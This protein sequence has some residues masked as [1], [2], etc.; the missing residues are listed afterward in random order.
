MRHWTYGLLAAIGRAPAHPAT[1]HPCPAP[2]TNKRSRGS[3]TRGARHQSAAA[4]QDRS[5]PISRD[6]GC[7]RGRVCTVCGRLGASG[8]RRARGLS[9]RVMCCRRGNAAPPPRSALGLARATG[10][11]RLARR[12]NARRVWR[13]AGGP[14]HRVMVRGGSWHVASATPIRV[15]QRQSSRLSRV[16]HPGSRGLYRAPPS[17][18][19]P[20]CFCSCSVLRARQP[21]WRRRRDGPGEDGSGRDARDA[22]RC[23]GPGMQSTVNI[24]A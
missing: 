19:S 17:D 16:R 7:E 15:S 12:H 13:V 21:M 3:R 2:C 9:Q 11:A 23:G 6:N 1:Q 22:D 10:A 20:W 18:G 24:V 14:S 5:A 4:D 8:A